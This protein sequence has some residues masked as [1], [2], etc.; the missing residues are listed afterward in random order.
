MIDP[1]FLKAVG[2][3][4]DKYK[5]TPSWLAAHLMGYEIQ[6]ILKD[7]VLIDTPKVDLR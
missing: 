3:L 7:N 2:E 1:T 4:S 5:D 6:Q